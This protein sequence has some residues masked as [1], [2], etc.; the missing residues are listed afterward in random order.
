MDVGMTCLG[1]A[2]KSLGKDT[3]SFLKTKVAGWH[4]KSSKQSERQ[5]EMER[6]L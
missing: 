2:E 6:T 3:Q 5:E 1:E 4:K